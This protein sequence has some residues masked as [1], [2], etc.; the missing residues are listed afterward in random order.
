MYSLMGA[1]ANGNSGLNPLISCKMWRT[2]ALPRMLY[3]LEMCN[4][5]QADVGT[6]ECV[7]KRILRRIQC[8]PDRT[9]N[10]AVYGLLGMRP[11]EQELDV[12]KLSLLALIQHDEESLEHEIAL[13]QLAVRDIDESSWFMQCNTLLHKYHL[14]NVFR[15]RDTYTSKATL[16]EAIKKGVDNY[17]I[18]QWQSEAKDKSSLRYLN[19]NACDVGRVH[20]S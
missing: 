4:L 15:I 12:R 2:F 16:K 10:V 18:T 9:A 6:L 17:V 1:G 5:R 3:G 20:N 19:V 8:L 14:P 11:V 7:Q 13:R